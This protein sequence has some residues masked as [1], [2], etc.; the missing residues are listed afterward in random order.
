GLLGGSLCRALRA[1]SPPVRLS[2][3]GRSVDRLRPALEDGTV[4]RVGTLEEADLRGVDLAVVATPVVSSI[5]IIRDILDNNALGDGALV[6]DVGSVKEEIVR[7]V[8]D[9]PR[10]GRFVACHPMAGSEKTGYLHGRADLYE[11]SAVIITPHEKN[12]GDVLD[13][14]ARFW[15]CLGARTVR[16]SPAEHDALVA[17]TSHLPHMVSCVLVEQLA[18]ALEKDAGPAGLFIGRG[19]RDMTRIAAGSEE[20]W[21]EISALNAGNIAG[22]IDDFIGRLESLKGMIREA[23]ESPAV[24]NGYLA[25]IRKVREDIS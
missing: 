15:E 3:W 16:T 7:G 11:G 1:A 21:S 6:V 8:I 25:K 23:G 17:R 24:L 13:A 9:H 22:A 12:Q 19:F 14:V 4:D 18:G 2:A 10:A 5:A 20:I